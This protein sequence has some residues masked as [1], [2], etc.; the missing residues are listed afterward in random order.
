MLYMVNIGITINVYGFEEG[1]IFPRRISGRRGED[2]IHFLMIDNLK[3]INPMVKNSNKGYHYILIK[4][5][6]RLLG[7][8]GGY[9]K[10]F[11]PYCCH[12]FIKDNLIEV[13]LKKI[14]KNASNM[15]EQGKLCLNS[16]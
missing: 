8:N 11:C 1:L 6:N 16:G 12:G 9:A 10:K 5:L 13:K 3:P 4:N 14:W 7:K 2:L 15:V